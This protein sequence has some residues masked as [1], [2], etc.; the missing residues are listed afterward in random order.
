MGFAIREVRIKPTA[1]YD[2][3]GKVMIGAQIVVVFRDSALGPDR[4]A[5]SRMNY[6]VDDTPG[7]REYHKHAFLERTKQWL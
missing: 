3:W 4:F 2:A 7:M 6:A 5:L 1:I